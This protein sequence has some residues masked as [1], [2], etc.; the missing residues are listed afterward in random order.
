MFQLIFN[1]YDIV[2]LILKGNERSNVNI[3][4]YI[5]ILIFISVLLAKSQGARDSFENEMK[6]HSKI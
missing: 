3:D 2:L 1:N 5:N 4:I 6:N